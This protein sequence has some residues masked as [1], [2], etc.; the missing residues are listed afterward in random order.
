[1]GEWTVCLGSDDVQTAP[2]GL[3][4]GQYLDRSNRE[5]TFRNLGGSGRALRTYYGPNC[6]C[7]KGYH[8]PAA[9]LF[10]IDTDFHLPPA[11]IADLKPYLNEHWQVQVID[12]ELDQMPFQLSSYPANSP[13][14]HNSEF[15]GMDVTGAL[16]HFGTGIAIASMLH[17]VV[18]LHNPDM[19]GALMSAVNDHVVDKWLNKEPRLRGT[20]YISGED[21]VA[22]VAEIDRLAD[23]KRFVQVML[24]AMQE[25]HHGNRMYWP[26]YEAIERHG[27]T[28]AIHAGSLYRVPPSVA[29]WPSYQFEDYIMQGNVFEN[30][31]VGLLGE[32]V[33]QKFPK[34]QFVFLESGFAWLATTLWRIDKT[35]RGVRQEVPWLDRRPSEIVEGRIFMGLQPVDPPS[36]TELQQV[37]KH[38]GRTD[39]LLY[40]TDYP[41]RQF[42]GDSPLPE[43]LPD[44]ALP[45]ILAG[46]ALKAY[47]R[48]AV[49]PAV[50]LL[51]GAL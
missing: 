20:I 44:D 2:V 32:G 16:D 39:M 51:E 9:E 29:G 12:R 23:D 17:G 27:L 38:I 8:M 35:W 19:R 48:L 47:P 21:P 30:I 7:S 36:P 31:L 13:M 15:A 45:G 43:G 3:R 6:E 14:T 49:D 24:L 46:N 41:H 26:I 10:R 1:M 18:A 40:S 37:L 4:S 5:K 28:L 25:I 34:L 11:T 42:T 33:L 22:A 50:K